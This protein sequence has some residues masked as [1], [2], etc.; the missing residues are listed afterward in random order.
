MAEPDPDDE[1]EERR[2]RA[3]LI[4]L[5]VAVVII[6]AGVALML[7]VRHGIER[8]DCILAGHPDCEPVDTSAGH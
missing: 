2:S 7:A 5:A 1:D 8:Q 4:V 3:N 6:V